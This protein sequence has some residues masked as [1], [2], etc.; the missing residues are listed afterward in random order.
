MK[1]NKGHASNNQKKEEYLKC[2]I[3]SFFDIA[4]KNALKIKKL[5][6]LRELLVAQ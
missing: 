4:H 3:D 6:N 2:I 5:W 1:E